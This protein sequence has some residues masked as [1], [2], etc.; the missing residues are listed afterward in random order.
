LDKKDSRIPPLEEVKEEV[1]RKV[2]RVKCEEKARQVAEEGLKQIQTERRG[3]DCQGAA[4]PDGRDSFFTRT[5][6]VIPKIGPVSE[7]SNLLSSLTEKNPSPKEVLRTK[8]G[9]LW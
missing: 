7:F 1:K 5:G 6:G 4:A 9:Y 8:E 2:I 3:R